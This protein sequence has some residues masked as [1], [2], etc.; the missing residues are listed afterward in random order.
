MRGMTYSFT[1]MQKWHLIRIQALK[2]YVPY[3]KL[4]LQLFQKTCCQIYLL[5]KHPY[6][7]IW[8]LFLRT[9]VNLPCS[10]TLSLMNSGVGTD[11]SE[12]K[13]IICCLRSVKV[14]SLEISTSPRQSGH[15]GLKMLSLLNF[16][17]GG[18]SESLF[19]DF[20]L[21]SKTCN[22]QMRDDDWFNGFT[23]F[24]AVFQ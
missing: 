7:N 24:L 11:R 15:T 10:I 6:F 12:V 5:C 17:W 19:V 16:L 21:I 1:G 18:F 8:S 22:L 20:S 14:A 9:F 3:V 2:H 13:V 23:S 4:K